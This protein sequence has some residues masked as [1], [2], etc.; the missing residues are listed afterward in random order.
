MAMVAER[1]SKGVK[2]GQDSRCASPPTEPHAVPVPC[3]VGL[4]GGYAQLP[5]AF[6][7]SVL[8]KLP[9]DQRLTAQLV[10]RQWRAVAGEPNLWADLDVGGG[11]GVALPLR[12]DKRDALLWAAAHRAGPR[13]RRV[14]VVR[15]DAALLAALLEQHPGVEELICEAPD[16]AAVL[17]RDARL[18]P[19]KVEEL[20]L[21][22]PSLRLLAATV[23]PCA[24]S[25][26]CELL[27][28]PF[29]APLRCDHLHVVDF[30]RTSDVTAFAAVAGRHTTLQALTLSEAPLNLPPALSSVLELAVSLH[31]RAL[32][33]T[34]CHLRPASLV[35][36]ASLI[37]R[38]QLEALTLS[39]V[40]D[41]PH[42]LAGV[43]LHALCDALPVSNLRALALHHAGAWEAAEAPA[44][45]D[46]LARA[47]H[48]MD[49]CI[50]DAEAP[51]E[52]KDA[53]GTALGALV[54]SDGLTNLTL[55]SFLGDAELGP[56]FRSLG[57]VKRLRRLELSCADLTPS[58][59]R[60]TVLPAA[61][62]NASLRL[63]A[64]NSMHERAAP[65]LR[66]AMVC[67]RDR[68][69]VEGSE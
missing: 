9:C 32:C 22:G 14:R 36:L 53:L 3:D 17:L 37:R 30:A 58:F 31:L 29:F 49:V 62:A 39:C 24:A 57:A 12:L 44:L 56:L 67:V 35:G 28:E 15:P 20:L 11:S 38:G 47:P 63:L 16:E 59:A 54:A 52:V 55:G 60:N 50:T 43:G 41:E 4:E 46:A 25:V 64:V 18:A 26:A 66:R 45:L 61:R 8:A 33:L 13:L 42:L 6:L 48:L 68:E 7:Q 21:L 10:C 23:G 51:A 5:S 69:A 19:A 34:A 40:P 65:A 2:P 1:E 27:S